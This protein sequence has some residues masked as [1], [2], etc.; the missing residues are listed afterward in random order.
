MSLIDKLAIKPLLYA[1][2]ALLL[3]TAILAVG[4]YVHAAKLQADLDVQTVSASSANAAYM[5]SRTRVAELTA[6]NKGWQATTS[7][8]RDE[9]KRA[10]DQLVEVRQQGAEAVAA[11]EARAADADRTLKT[12][13]DRYA[14]QVKETAC[15]QALQNVEAVCP[16]FRGY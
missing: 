6:A 2:G 9:I 10:Q 3:M 11:A 8:L 12:F 7:T 4:W 14:V 16:A 1:I 15:A 13:M 5:T